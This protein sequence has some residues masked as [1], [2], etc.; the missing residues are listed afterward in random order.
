MMIVT[1]YFMKKN[2]WGKFGDK[3]SPC[4]H[5]KSHRITPFKI[6]KWTLIISK[7]TVNEISLKL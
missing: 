1:G 3:A 6:S 2:G 7:Y 4:P 5:F